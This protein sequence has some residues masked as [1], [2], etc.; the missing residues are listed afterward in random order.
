LQR[1]NVDMT[2]RAGTSLEFAFVC[3]LSDGLHARP[4]SHLAEAAND[5]VSECFLTNLRTGSVANLKSV[6]AIISAD[7]RQGDQCTVQ[8]RGSDEQAAHAA[9]FR[10]VEQALPGCDVPL[11]G[12][13]LTSA[14]GTLPRALRAAEMKCCFGS[15]VS[16]GI[17]QGKVV[18][19]GGV[20][21]PTGL[22]EPVV[23]DPETELGQIKR[24]IASVRSRIREKLTRQ[25]S[26]TEIAVLQAD[27]AIASDVSFAQKLTEN[28][29]QGRSAGQAVMEAGEF[30]MNLLR[31]SDR[32]YIRERALD[33][34]EICLQLLEEIYGVDLVTSPIELREPSIVVAETLAPQQLLGLDRRWLRALVLEYSG[35]TSHAVILA[36]SLGIPTLVGVKNA[37]PQLAAGQEVVVDAIRG[38]IVTQVSPAVQ[39]FYE[40]E[41]RTLALR[42]EFLP[43]QTTGP[44]IT[45]DGK[46]LE[47][48]ANASSYEELSLAFE[49][50][51]DGIGLFR[52][53]MA[54]LH[55]D[56]AP[57]E[58]EQFAIYS[59]AARIAT[60]RPVIIRTFDLG[61]DKVAPYLNLPAEGNPFLGYRGVRIYAEHRELL[62]AQ[63]RA[64]LRASAFGNVPI[65]V[66]MIS[67]LDEVLRFKEEISEAKQDLARAGIAFQ[68][69]IRIGVM[70]EVPS[71]GFIL[72]QLCAEVDFFSLGTNELNQYFLAVDRDNTKLAKL[73]NVLHPGFLRFLRKIVH[74]IHEAGKWVGMC[75]E[76]AAEI[77]HLP[78][79]VGLGLD[80]ISLPAAEIPQFKRAIS[81]LSAIDCERTLDRVI[82][83]RDKIE[84]EALLEQAQPSWSTQPLLSKELVLLGSESNNK[85][86]AIQEIVDA[87]YI[88]GR[89]GD[90]QRLE[91]ALWSREAVYSTGLGYGFAAPHCKTEAVIADSIG[92]LKLKQA[93]DWGS[94]DR[95]PVTMI[96]LI[97]MRE[98]QLANRHMQVFSK[99]ARKLM[100][101][102][103]RGHLLAVENAHDMATYLARQLDISLH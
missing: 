65:M 94:V 90:R 102:D 23:T 68:Q 25:K 74:D 13:G 88:A 30:F 84:L 73:S 14:N 17:G 35:A 92:V 72:D 31:R 12:I 78:L 100:S 61:G 75:G 15:P 70:I 29:S 83:C 81:Q 96:I 10:F 91:E 42:R 24:A 60:G 44:A 82:A 52:T 18:L 80:E 69:H 62:Q 3:T 86:E 71:S 50:G 39:R 32:E 85:E 41:Q 37:R 11:A 8:V 33:V 93:I 34:E 98:P 4:A 99:L 48:A 47:V 79:L 6:L 57:S 5:F 21:L 58:E 36:R 7:V 59:E 87:F 22:N 89:T 43:V 2:Q 103:F 63:L 67:S 46:T 76:M 66:P 97:A 38:F 53:E 77:R 55:R 20:T 49:N 26:S 9:L 16:S 40:R 19:L 45:A 54:F 64:I 56:C 95:E 51:A 28:V 27:L 1:S 101:E